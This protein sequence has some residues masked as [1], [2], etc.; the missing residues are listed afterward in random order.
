MGHK[1][2]FS[3]DGK[4]LF[5]MGEDSHSFALRDASTGKP[6]L[7]ILRPAGQGSAHCFLAG[8]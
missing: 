4:K 2:G 5:W 8:R 6:L 1:A 3:P 7:S